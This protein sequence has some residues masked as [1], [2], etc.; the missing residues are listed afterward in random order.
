MTKVTI[1]PFLYA[2]WP[3][4]CLVAGAGFLAIGYT[5]PAMVMCGYSAWIFGVRWE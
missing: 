4:V 3:W 2:A 1:P 5:L